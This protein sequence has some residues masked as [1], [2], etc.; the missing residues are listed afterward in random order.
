[1]INTTSILIQLSLYDLYNDT[2]FRVFIYIFNFKFSYE[3]FIQNVKYIR[4]KRYEII[5]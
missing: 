2:N 4:V 5:L 1:M 3:I